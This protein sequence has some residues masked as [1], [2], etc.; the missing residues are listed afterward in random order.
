[1]SPDVLANLPA[2]ALL[3]DLDARG[4]RLLVRRGNLATTTPERLTEADRA[5][6]RQHKRDLLVL[7]LI[8]DDRTLDRLLALR[9]GT[10]GRQRAATGCH[11]C[12]G[13][14]PSDRPRGRCGF[15]ALATRLYAGGP[16]PPDVITLF[17]VSLRGP[18]MLPV[19]G[20]PF[21]LAVPA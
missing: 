8:C 20:L 10:L 16:V 12:G 17:D 6:L 11:Q 9:A 15:C 13:A 4:V 1:M 19:T 14:M 18:R 7:V 5:V 3:L 2:R 21:D